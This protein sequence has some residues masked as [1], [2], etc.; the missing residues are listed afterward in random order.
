MKKFIFLF[1]ITFS[2]CVFAQDKID[3]VQE[4]KIQIEQQKMQMQYQLDWFKA[5]YMKEQ[6]EE[7]LKI[8]KSK[9]DLEA[10]QMYDGNPYN[11]A[12]NFNK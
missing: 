4:S 1:L 3:T 7:K 6:G 10:K 5:N 12:V 9:V 8:E 11:D 2:S